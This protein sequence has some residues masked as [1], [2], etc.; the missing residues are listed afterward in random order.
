MLY[1]FVTGGAI[2]MTSAWPVTALSIEKESEKIMSIVFDIVRTIRNIRA[3]SK[4]PPSELRDIVLIV[5]E[6][7]REGIEANT[8]II[9]GLCRG[10]GLT[11]GK[12]PEK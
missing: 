11:I 2:L 1:G 10:L 8:R 6:G 7:Y 5:P 3:E 4:I 9:S 12:K